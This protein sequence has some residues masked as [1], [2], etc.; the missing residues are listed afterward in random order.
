MFNKISAILI[1]SMLIFITGCAPQV[2]GTTNKK[3]IES[4]AISSN[5]IKPQKPNYIVEVFWLG[6]SHCQDINPHIKEEAKKHP[7]VELILV[8]APFNPQWIKDARIYYAASEMGVTATELFDLYKTKRTNKEDFPTAVEIGEYITKKGMSSFK[9]NSIL[10]S[11]QLDDKIEQ[12]NNYISN[13][14]INGTPAFILNGK[15]LI[16]NE[17]VNSY[18]GMAEKVFETFKTN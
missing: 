9:F 17:G 16:S 12:A 18:K 5:F 4:K 10:K 15:T 11:K 13:F 6:C 1:S 14:D 3:K 2:D 8:P 7:E